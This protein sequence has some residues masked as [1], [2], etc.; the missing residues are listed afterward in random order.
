MCRDK[1]QGIIAFAYNEPV[2]WFKYIMDVMDVASDFYLVLVTNGL[3]NEESLGE[4]CSVANAI[5]WT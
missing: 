1:G 3:I 4:L 2:I 5:T